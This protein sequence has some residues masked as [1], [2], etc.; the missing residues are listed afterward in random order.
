[1][2]ENKVTALQVKHNKAIISNFKIPSEMRVAPHFK[3]F[4]YF[5]QKIA[6]FGALDTW[7]GA[8][9]WQKMAPSYSFPSIEM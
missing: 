7:I 4:A 2:I 5:S 8:W 1:M 6:I 3:V 9:N